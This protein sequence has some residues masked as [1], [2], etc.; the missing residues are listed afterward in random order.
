[1]KHTIFSYLSDN[2]SGYYSFDP[3]EGE[4]YGYDNLIWSHPDIDKPSETELQKNVDQLNADEPYKQ[5]R[6][7]RNQMLKRTDIYGLADYPFKDDNHK[8]A[9]LT[10]RQQL[11]DLPSMSSPTLDSNHSLDPNSVKWPQEP[12][13]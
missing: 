9:W 6:E 7:I 4:P 12:E 3:P 8:T 10:Y 1:M 11:R 13:S 2:Y 5:L